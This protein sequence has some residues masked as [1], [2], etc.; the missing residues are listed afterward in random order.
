MSIKDRILSGGVKRSAKVD[1]NAGLVTPSKTTGA[2]EL[3][4][5]V[6]KPASKMA[7]LTPQ[8][9]AS[10]F[11]FE[12]RKQSDLATPCNWKHLRSFSTGTMDFSVSLPS[13]AFDSII[14]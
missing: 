3:S 5:N 6:K 9:R 7:M 10:S 8:K 11:P 12:D 4:S 14:H 2:I 1:S 13:L